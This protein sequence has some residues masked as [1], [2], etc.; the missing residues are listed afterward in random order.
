M[1]TSREL[2]AKYGKPNVTG[3]GYLTTIVLP[4]PMRL[5]WDLDTNP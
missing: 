5:A 1:I 4:Y 2:I 3:E